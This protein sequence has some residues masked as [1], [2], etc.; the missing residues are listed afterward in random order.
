MSYVVVVMS[1]A[2]PSTSSSSLSPDSLSTKR[3]FL[4][5]TASPA[6]AA[7]VTPAPLVGG[8]DCVTNRAPPS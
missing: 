4:M 3:L 6:M 5:M 1:I 8:A 7:A 2:P